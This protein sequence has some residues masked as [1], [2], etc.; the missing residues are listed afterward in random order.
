MT[1]GQ[2][3]NF[4]YGSDEVLTSAWAMTLVHDPASG[5]VTPTDLGPTHET[6]SY[7]AY[8]AEQTFTAMA[9]V[10]TPDAKGNRTKGGTACQLVT[11]QDVGG[12]G[13]LQ[14][15]VRRKRKHDQETTFACAP[16]MVYYRGRE[17]HGPLALFNMVELQ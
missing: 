7:D 14:T 5:F 6:R 1:G 9:H 4:D 11:D 8:G 13:Y 2:T 17:G 10:A 16:R 3:I 15:P 12:L